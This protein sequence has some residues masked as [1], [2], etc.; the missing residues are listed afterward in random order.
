MYSYYNANHFITLAVHYWVI[1]GK[2]MHLSNLKTESNSQTMTLTSVLV[3]VLIVLSSN[4]C[5]LGDKVLFTR[6]RV[7][8]MISGK[9]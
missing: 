9:L 2:L 5:Y 4:C 3:C 1:Y 7:E 6:A 8:L